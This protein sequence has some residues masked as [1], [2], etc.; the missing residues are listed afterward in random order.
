ME[1]LDEIYKILENFKEENM[2]EIFDQVINSETYKLTPVG[3]CGAIVSYFSHYTLCDKN[4][5]MSQ[6]LKFLFQ[7]VPDHSLEVH[8]NFLLLWIRSSDEK[9]LNYQIDCLEEFAPQLHEYEFENKNKNTFCHLAIAQLMERCQNCILP[10]EDCD[11][12]EPIPSKEFLEKSSNLI[13]SKRA[14]TYRGRLHMVTTRIFPAFASFAMSKNSVPLEFERNDDLIGVYLQK[15]ASPS[16]LVP[17][18]FKSIV[19]YLKK[20][21]CVEYKNRIERIPSRV[22]TSLDNLQNQSYLQDPE[23]CLQISIMGLILEQANKEKDAN[24]NLFAP[25]VQRFASMCNVD[26]SMIINTVIRAESTYLKNGTLDASYDV[27]IIS[28]KCDPVP[29]KPFTPLLPTFEIEPEQ[30][31]D[32]KTDFDMNDDLFDKESA[33]KHIESFAGEDEEKWFEGNENNQ[34]RAARLCVSYDM[35]R[36]D[37]E[38]ISLIPKNSNE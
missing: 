4:M 3:A 32:N 25:L 14:S 31:E 13:R 22:L 6:F 20:V 23:V 33:R 21:N 24:E 30:N 9:A 37:S 19:S 17:Q 1:G 35:D 15:L 18:D 7:N 2:F 5:V 12:D 34:W 38:S 11:L 27:S 16:K 26:G 10:D 8:F 36:L 29:E 28:D